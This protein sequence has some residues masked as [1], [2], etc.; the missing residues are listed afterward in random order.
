[1][2]GKSLDAFTMLPVPSFILFY[3]SKPNVYLN[4]DS[5]LVH[6]PWIYYMQWPIVG[7][8]ADDYHLILRL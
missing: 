7:T 3:L 4:I 5:L 1:M 6:L 8:N 2:G